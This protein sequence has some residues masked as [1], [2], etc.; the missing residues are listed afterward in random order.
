MKTGHPGI[1]C[2][3]E[4]PK[5]IRKIEMVLM[6]QTSLHVGSLEMSQVNR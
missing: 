5:I 6:Q 3:A 2:V 4:L 1:V